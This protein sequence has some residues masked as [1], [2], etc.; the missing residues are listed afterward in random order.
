MQYIKMR[1]IDVEGV[2]EL[3]ATRCCQPELNILVISLNR[4]STAVSSMKI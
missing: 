4:F 3:L 1:L 2:D